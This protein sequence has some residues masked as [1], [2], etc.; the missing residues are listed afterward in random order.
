M[1]GKSSQD[2]SSDVF[3]SPIEWDSME[4]RPL[5]MG[6]WYLYKVICLLNV[7]IKQLEDWKNKDESS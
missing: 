2:L 4:I 1:S 6:V 7:N 5:F 3:I